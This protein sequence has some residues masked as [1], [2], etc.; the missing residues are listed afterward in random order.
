MKSEKITAFALAIS[1]GVVC[2]DFTNPLR[3]S[4]KCNKFDITCNP[5]IKPIT[6]P[7]AEQ[8]WGEAGA[9]AYPAA[10]NVMLRRNTDSKRLSDSQKRYL[11]PHFG[12]LVDRVVVT[13]GSSMMDQWGDINLSGVDTA[14]QTYC[15]RIYIQDSYKPDN[16]QQLVTL[17]HEMTHSKQCEEL[18]GEGKFGF[19][20]FREFKRAGL[21]YENN[22]LEREAYSFE[23]QF[24][25]S[26][27]SSQSSGGVDYEDLT[28]QLYRS[29]LGREPDP[30][31]FSDNVNA[32]RQHNFE[33]VRAGMSGSQESRNNINNL[34]RQY[35]CRDADPG[36]M[37]FH[38]NLL[39]SGQMALD[40]I[41]NGIA[42]GAEA[43]QHKNGCR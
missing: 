41:R 40:Q 5:H 34:Y 12:D 21:N 27:S 20:Y 2:A 16:T 8:A 14:A 31:G 25:S 13:Y 37:D 28:R 10:A 19:H 11:R 35:L 23:N 36:G 17:A 15:N 6:K 33:W 7:L 32:M 22:K 38:I 24:A 3:A 39:A 43:Q 18:G 26:L 9:V 42:N 1:L 30:S 4:A 29:I